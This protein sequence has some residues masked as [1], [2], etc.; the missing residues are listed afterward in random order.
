M[1]SAGKSAAPAAAG[2]AADS[3]RAAINDFIF[4]PPFDRG[5]LIAPGR[6]GPEGLWKAVDMRTKIEQN[7]NIKGK[8]ATMTDFLRDLAAF[9]SMA[10]FVASFSVILFGI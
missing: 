6:A 10:M 2:R 5:D 4:F 8:G 1:R 7:G 9:T 3:R